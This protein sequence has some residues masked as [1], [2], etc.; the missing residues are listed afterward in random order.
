MLKRQKTAEVVGEKEN[1]V[2]CLDSLG[3]AKRRSA[4]MIKNLVNSYKN[5]FRPKRF[6]KD[7]QRRE[8]FH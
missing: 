3:A 8:W 5:V 1:I 6:G 7:V 2:T 4:T